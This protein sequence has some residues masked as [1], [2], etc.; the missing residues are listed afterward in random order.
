MQCLREGSNS[1]YTFYFHE[2]YTV[3]TNYFV[4]ANVAARGGPTGYSRQDS[5]Y[6]KL[7]GLSYYAFDTFDQTVRS[8]TTFSSKAFRFI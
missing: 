7:F 2:N 8:T 6:S 4:A 1:V 5:N 3:T